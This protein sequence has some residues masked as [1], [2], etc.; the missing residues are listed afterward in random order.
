MFITIK[1]PPLDAIL[2]QMNPV[3]IF[4]H[5]YL[6]VSFNIIFPCTFMSPEWSGLFKYP[7]ATVH[8]I[9]TF[10]AILSINAYLHFNI[11]ET[12][13][14]FPRVLEERSA[15]PHLQSLVDPSLTSFTVSDV[16]HHV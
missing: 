3:Q 5:F 12:R 15:S 8:K 11:V 4:T 7:T 1:S 13:I 10:F 6:K 16:L 2:N 9:L 14:N